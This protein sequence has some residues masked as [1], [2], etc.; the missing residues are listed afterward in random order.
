MDK[1]IVFLISS[2]SGGGAEGVCVSLANGFVLNGRKVTLAVLRSDND[3]RS[4]DLHKDVKLIRLN[5]RHART[6][7]IS[8]Y[9][10]L[11]LLKPSKIL[12]FNHQLAVLLI[13][14]RRLTSLNFRIYS[15]NI[16]NLSLKK[17]NERSLWHKYA[18]GFI[19]NFFYRGVDKVIAQSKG[20][21]DDLVN[22]FGFEEK[23]VVVINNPLNPKIEQ[24]ADE[25]VLY[26][27]RQRNYLLCIGRLEQVKAFHYAVEAFAAISSKYPFLRLKILG[28][29]SLLNELRQCAVRFGVGDKV[30]FEGYRQDTIPYFLNAKATVL[31]SLYEGFP[32]VLIESIALGTPVVSFDCESGP[33]EIIENDVNGYLVKYLD[34]ED[35]KECLCRVIDKAWDP[36]SVSSTAEKYHSLY[37][38]KEYIDAVS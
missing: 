20:M 18:V 24:S 33:G 28:Q 6:S 17:Q 26:A 25:S 31:T 12:V 22:N 29:G 38:L 7:V 9:R 13:V 30:D 16:S 1:E 37:I 10:F 14:I 5:C 35:L 23:Q 11:S 34:K 15:R 21:K 2:L 32:N 36:L 3:V 4:Q 8:L 19:V 27:D